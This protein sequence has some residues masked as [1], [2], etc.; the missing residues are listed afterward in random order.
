MRKQPSVLGGFGRHVYLKIELEDM[1][2]NT[3]FA[4][5]ETFQIGGPAENYR[6]TVGGYS[7]DAGT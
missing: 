2:G 5:Y 6:L 1:A 7:G 4:N 3:R